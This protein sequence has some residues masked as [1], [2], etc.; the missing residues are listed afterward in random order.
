MGNDRLDS[1]GRELATV[2]SLYESYLVDSCK[3]QRLTSKMCEAKQVGINQIISSSFLSLRINPENTPDFQE[4]VDSIRR[5][6]LLHP[7]IVR[8]SKS[9][10]VLEL[11]AGYRRLVACKKL[12]MSY[13]SATVL[14]LED[15]EA[16]EV[17]LI[18][19]LQRQSLDPIEEAEGFNRYVLSFG[20]G[21]ITGLAR[22]IGKSE[23]YVSHRLLLLGLPKVIQEKI[24]RRLLKSSQ[25]TELVWIKDSQKQIELSNEVVSGQLS[26]AQTRAAAI[27]LKSGKKTTAAE[28]VKEALKAEDDGNHENH[29]EDNHPW[30]TYHTDSGK[31]PTTSLLNRAILIHRS[32]L[33]GI[34]LLIEQ[35]MAESA[36]GKS[37]VQLLMKQRN[38]VH[39]GLDELIN[40]RMSAGRDQ[41]S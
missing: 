32:A 24:S 39:S 16:L 30:P 23:E 19:N 33:A 7:L 3:M 11:V 25:A 38:S 36:Q 29:E 12:G 37:V 17:A 28:A 13:V 27:L 20:R 14:D 31:N 9:G 6:G 34:D 8:P 4:L 40:A 18:E 10:D 2:P 41:E 21:S 5:H 35:A 1:V 22:R 26:F 15:R